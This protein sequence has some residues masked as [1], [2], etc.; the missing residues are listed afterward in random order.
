MW[1][2]VC[3][4]LSLLRTMLGP[5]AIPCPGLDLSSSFATV[6]ATSLGAAATTT[7]SPYTN[8][9]DFLVGARPRPPCPNSCLLG[10]LP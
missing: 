1:P 2:V 5:A 10:T 9:L 6:V 8:D 4:Q 7:F 3:A